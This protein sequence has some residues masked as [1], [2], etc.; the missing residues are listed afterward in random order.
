MNK[1]H[2]T[3]NYTSCKCITN[4]LLRDRENNVCTISR[5]MKQNDNLINEGK[6]KKFKIHYTCIIKIRN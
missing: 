2:E 4:K 6:G 3:E 1:F 5:Y